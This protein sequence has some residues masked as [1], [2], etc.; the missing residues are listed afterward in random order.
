MENP[1]SPFASWDES[2]KAMLDMKFKLAQSKKQKIY[3]SGRITGMENK[4]FLLFGLAEKE[5]QH[6][7]FEIVNPMRLP[8]DHDKSWR[9]YMNICLKALVD[10][11]AIYML[12]NYKES[13]GA[14]VELQLA[15]SLG[16]NV[17]FQK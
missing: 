3:I 16:I 11:E 2:Q 6:M 4:A 14:Q 10:C 5:I 8:D 1:K 12:T 15:L 17:I 13:R 7:N 9:S